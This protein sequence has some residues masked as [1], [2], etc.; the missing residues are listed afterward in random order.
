MTLVAY[1]YSDFSG[2]NTCCLSVLII[3]IC[4][5]CVLLPCRITLAHD[6]YIKIN[7]VIEQSTPPPPSPVFS[8]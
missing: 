7:V 3:I 6:Q 8:L 5:I 1:D 2:L 4:S